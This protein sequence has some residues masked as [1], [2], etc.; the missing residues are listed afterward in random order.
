MRSGSKAL[1][2]NA[3][4]LH[5]V[6]SV[7]TALP[8]QV[9]RRGSGTE[10]SQR[11]NDRSSDSLVSGTRDKRLGIERLCQA[12]HSLLADEIYSIASLDHLLN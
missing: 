1:C 6:S 8:R 12:A 7:G 4:R 2:A 3:A 11:S 5:S 10:R 9:E